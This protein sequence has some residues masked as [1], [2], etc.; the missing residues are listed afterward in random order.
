LEM[1]NCIIKDWRASWWPSNYCCGWWS[2]SVNSSWSNSCSS[3]ALVSTFESDIKK[4][5]SLSSRSCSGRTKTG[6]GIERFD[7]PLINSP[8]ILIKPSSL[9]LC[10]Q[11]SCCS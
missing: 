8:R 6:S 9:L 11:M 4:T 3:Q 5:R 10:W 7:H 2:L 1:I